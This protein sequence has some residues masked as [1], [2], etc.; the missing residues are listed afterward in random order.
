MA[1]STGLSSFPG[2]PSSPE[3][4]PPP[5]RI[6]RLPPALLPED[7]NNDDVASPEEHKFWWCL[8]DF[9]GLLLLGLEDLGEELLDCPEVVEEEELLLALEVGEDETLREP[10]LLGSCGGGSI[11]LSSWVCWI[12]W[13]MSSSCSFKEDGEHAPVKIGLG[14]PTPT[15]QL[16]SRQDDG[17]SSLPP[18]SSNPNTPPELPFPIW[19]HHQKPNYYE[20]SS[21]NPSH[22]HTPLH[23]YLH[24]QGSLCIRIQY[25]IVHVFHKF[26]NARREDIKHEIS[27]KRQ[28]LYNEDSVW[29]LSEPIT[30]NYFLMLPIWSTFIKLLMSLLVCER[31][32]WRYEPEIMIWKKTHNTYRGGFGIFPYFLNNDCDTLVSEVNSLFLL[33]ER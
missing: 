9:L 10:Q 8:L 26:I 2:F 28:M 33:R 32:L 14:G 20:G 3:P 1:H 4:S 11:A 15:T 5:P 25:I 27:I 29:R 31:D 16:P 23:T 17:D 19:N 12:I 24:S 22:T 13:W 7:P 6:E 21:K 30:H 18:L